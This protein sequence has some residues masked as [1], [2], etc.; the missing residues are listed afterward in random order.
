MDKKIRIG[1]LLFPNLL[2]MDF[3]GP[4]GVLAA[5]GIQKNVSIDL[6][7]KNALPLLSSDKLV[8]TPTLAME[9]CPPLD[10]VCVP[11]GGGILPL[12]EDE[13]VL[14]FL[15]KQATGARYVTSICTGA[16]VLGAAGLLTGY[17]ATTHWQS[18]DLLVEFGATPV[19]QR[20][21]IDGNRITAAGVSAGID[22]AIRLSGLLWGENVAQEIQLGMEYAPDPPFASGSPE[23]APAHI[24]RVLQEKN[25]GRQKTRGEAVK[26]AAAKLKLYSKNNQ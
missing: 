12:L 18:M 26:K 7:W 16:L 21:V 2:Q 5:A 15:R 25:A 9:D 6:V 11:G 17:Q 8:L 23:Q 22:M 13:E 1:F 10:V 24:L 3:T 19:R 20:V 14:S 4:Y